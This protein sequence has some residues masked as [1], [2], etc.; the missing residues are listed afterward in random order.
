MFY[1]SGGGTVDADP[2]TQKRKP[3]GQLGNTN[4]VKHGAYSRWFRQ[5]EVNDLDQIDG[6][7]LHGEIAMLRVLMQRLFEQVSAETP[8][9]E[10]MSMALTA[11]GKG[12]FHLGG[13]MRAEK[14][15]AGA[16]NEL[17]DKLTKALAGVVAE[18]EK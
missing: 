6:S 9:L 1:L 8:D 13:L 14:N 11:L 18:L 17:A 7:D 2:Q 12:A 15:L 3:G 10:T 5:M 4:A 16:R